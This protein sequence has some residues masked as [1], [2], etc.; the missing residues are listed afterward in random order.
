[1]KM[2]PLN[3]HLLY[4]I[5]TLM[6]SFYGPKEYLNYNK[7]PVFLFMTV[8]LVF[9]IIGFRI[10]FYSKTIRLRP[11]TIN[12][13][14]L[15]K[16]SIFISIGLYMIN[17]AYLYGQGRLSFSLTTMGEN[18]N[19][20]YEYYGDKK[21]TSLFTFEIIFLVLTA[22]PKYISLALGFYF[23]DSL[24]KKTKY[25]FLSLLVLI[26]IT[27]TFSSGNQKSLGDIVIFGGVALL[28]K[29]I[30][31][32][33]TQRKTLIRR[34]IVVFFALF[35]VLSYSQ[36]TRLSS[37][38]I[39]YYEINQHMASYS[40]FNFD[41][42]IFK[43]FGLEAG[44]GISA[45]ITGYLSN[46]Y[47]GLSKMLEIPFEWTYFM[48]SSLGLSNIFERIFN[49]EIFNRTY[50]YRME[51]LHNIPGKAH[52]HTV[53]PW[54]AG[55]FTFIGTL[56]LFLFFAYIYGKSWKEVYF[57]R[58]PISLLMF[59]LLTVM[60]IFVPAN[61][62]IFHGFDYLIISFITFYVW[63]KFHKRTNLYLQK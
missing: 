18:Y 12:Y 26:I 61:N 9:V 56:F 31:M 32:S 5:F 45:F 63:F 15:L 6:V 29:A 48:G 34:I 1:M 47:Y 46:G 37:R 2:L 30:R 62:Q 53:F 24:S 38:N 59:S 11:V 40:S 13:L 14:K 57:Y 50:L 60:F 49:I 58:N 21:E 17:M 35:S 43:I 3:F 22:L 39:S 52:W 20:Y 33:K 10:G 42:A 4:I 27:Q 16:L 28:A 41:H 44:L 23:F 51:I 7:L 8:Y 54:F 55:D 19:R 25:A 36:Y